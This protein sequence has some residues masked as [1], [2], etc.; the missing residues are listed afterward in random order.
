[1]SWFVFV[2]HDIPAFFMQRGLDAGFAIPSDGSLISF[3]TK[4]KAE[5][6]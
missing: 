6:N 4:C 2:V 5:Q 3:F 1:V